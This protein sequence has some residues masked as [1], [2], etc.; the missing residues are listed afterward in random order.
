MNECHRHASMESGEATPTNL[1]SPNTHEKGFYQI[2]IK[3]MEMDSKC[4]QF[5]IK[6]RLK[7]NRCPRCAR[8][9]GRHPQHF[10]HPFNP[11]KG[12]L[13]DFDDEEADG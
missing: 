10:Y 3:K 1:S 13:P 11:W 12:I 7:M 9:G 5:F 2:L 8:G 4:E 6:I